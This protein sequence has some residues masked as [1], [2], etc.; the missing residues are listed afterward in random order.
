[1]AAL[2]PPGPD[3]L[4]TYTVSYPTLDRTLSIR[5]QADFPYAIEGWEEVR[6]D[7]SGPNPPR[8]TTRATR[9]GRLRLDYWNHNH[10]GDE[11]YR[12]HLGLG[13]E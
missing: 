6:P 3:G 1:M 9:K 13:A 7:G 5:F 4:R 11:P 12:A 8:L 2:S 10:L